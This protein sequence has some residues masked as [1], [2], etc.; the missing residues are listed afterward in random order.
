MS[1]N[2][3]KGRS[4]RVKKSYLLISL[5]VLLGVMF[6][7]A[8]LISQSRMTFYSFEI[9]VPDEVV[10]NPGDNATVD[11]GILVT[12]MYWLH[13]FNLT[14]SGLPE[15]YEYKI[16][17]SWFENVRILREW[18]PQQGV[19]RIPDKFQILIHVPTDA[20][21]TQVVSVTGQEHQSFRQVSN[22]TYFALKIGGTPQEPF[23][24]VSDILVPELIKESEPFNLTFKL[25][26]KAPINASATVSIIIP[27]EWQSD[28]TSMNLSV[29]A[30]DSAFGVFKIIPTTEAGTIS[31][32][33]EYPFK[34]QII[35]FTKVGPYLIPGENITKTTTTQP[36]NQ[37]QGII[38]IIGSF[39][40]SFATQLNPVLIGIIIILVVVIVWLV[41]GIFKTVRSKGKGKGAG[42]GR[43]E[44]EKMK[45]QAEAATPVEATTGAAEAPKTVETTGVS[46]K[47]V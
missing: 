28:Q 17:P 37:T 3:E 7:V 33:V 4:M 6:S 38:G 47:E 39:V 5:A 11:G 27:D 24:N 9:N 31:L 41:I 45:S 1:I 15:G 18:N 44:P 22:S 8:P 19:Y 42:A 21:G 43:G 16:K 23:L 25:D 36:S 34:N 30:N 35:N 13:N 20:T 29:K 2:K 40:A 10:A 32:F 26:N 12:G 46:I 14:V